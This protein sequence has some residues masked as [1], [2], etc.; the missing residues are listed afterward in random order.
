MYGAAATSRSRSYLRALEGFEAAAR[1]LSFS[2]AA[3]ELNLT[4]SAISRQ[5][6]T[7]EQAVGAALFTRLTRKIVLTPA[8][9]QLYEATS[10]ALESLDR[11]IDRIRLN[12]A[13]QIITVSTLP[14]LGMAW[15]MPRLHRFAVEHPGIDVRISTSIAPVDAQLSQVDVAIRV[16][17]LPGRAYD[18]L[19]PRIDLQ[20]IERWKD[21]EVIE[22]FPDILTPVLSKSLYHSLGKT[23][24]ADVIRTLP[25]IHT[26]T[27]ER[28]WP[29]YLR[30]QHL[31]PPPPI[32][33]KFG[34]FFM[35]LEEARAG[36]GIALVPSVLLTAL[37]YADLQVLKLPS[38][39]SAGSY[40]ALFRTDTGQR[41]AVD[42]FKEWII[43]E[44]ELMRAQIAAF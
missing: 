26:T 7:L 13:P 14:T 4:Q 39:P 33:E 10:S 34:H 5:I 8:G 3:A 37:G 31:P 9:Q 42:R 12:D 41:A 23:D 20:M 16:G 40:F 22:L 27:R 28:G 32:R 18:P 36:R 6:S 19:A 25:L 15:L 38:V 2:R 11:S 35:C 24:P 21:F 29:D 1:L 43:S 30:A 17:T 44:S